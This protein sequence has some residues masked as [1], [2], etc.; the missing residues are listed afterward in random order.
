MNYHIVANHT[1]MLSAELGSLRLDELPSTGATLSDI[2]SWNVWF[3]LGGVLDGE[4]FQTASS[5]D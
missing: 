4:A 5:P 2:N 3:C 1:S